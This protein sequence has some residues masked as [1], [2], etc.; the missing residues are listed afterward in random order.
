MVFLGYACNIKQDYIRI[1]IQ[2]LETGASLLCILASFTIQNGPSEEFYQ[3]LH[4]ICIQNSHKLIMGNGVSMLACSF[5]TES[6]SKL[7]V[8]RTGIKARASLIAGL[9]IYIKT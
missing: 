9:G 4:K 6:S 3:D 2:L 7:L 1:N 5:L 8:M